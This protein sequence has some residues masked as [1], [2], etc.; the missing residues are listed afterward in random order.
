MGRL[1]LRRVGAVPVTPAVH[2]GLHLQL[3]VFELGFSPWIGQVY[4]PGC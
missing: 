4:L 3:L 1:A 2:E